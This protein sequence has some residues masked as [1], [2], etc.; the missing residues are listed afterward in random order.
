M[1]NPQ[2]TARERYL[3]DTAEEVLAR[4][5]IVRATDGKLGGCGMP[6]ALRKMDLACDAYQP[7]ETAH[8]NVR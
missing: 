4:W 6:E 8:E 3:L 2:T 7:E 1:S 5:A